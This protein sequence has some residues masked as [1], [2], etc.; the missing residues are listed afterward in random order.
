MFTP[1]NFKA[2]THQQRKSKEKT[3]IAHLKDLDRV[4]NSSTF[5]R[6]D[7]ITTREGKSKGHRHRSKLVLDIDSELNIVFLANMARNVNVS[8]T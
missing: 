6:E 8:T 7:I 5:K 3:A 4:L 1:D 2:A